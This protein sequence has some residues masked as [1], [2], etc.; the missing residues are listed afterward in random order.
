AES[1][2]AS[3][4]VDEVH[5]ELLPA[6]K[7][8]AVEQLLSGGGT[9]AFVGDGV[10]D[11]PV[12]MRADVGFAM[13][14]IGSDAAIEAADIVLMDDNIAK[15]ADVISIARKTLSIVRINVVFAI[16]VKVLVL[17]LGALGLAGMWAAV[18]AD[19]GVAVLAILNSMRMLWVR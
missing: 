5:A 4:G 11:A 2:A 14:A 16:G 3:C 7:V 6:D 9:V 17:I 15:I 10:N 18:F 8:T 13:G 12:L 19:V 1:V